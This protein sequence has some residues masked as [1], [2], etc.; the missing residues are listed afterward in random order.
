MLQKGENPKELLLEECKPKCLHWK[1]KLERCEKQL[2]TIVK[3]NPTK[4]CV[5]A[6]RDYATC[7]EACT[8]PIIHNNLV[9]E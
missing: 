6:F 1:E 7:T 9:I 4:S 8:Q 5:Y 3:I 2:E